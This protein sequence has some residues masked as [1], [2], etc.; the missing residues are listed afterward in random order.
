MERTEE[1]KLLREGTVV[2]LGGEEYR[3]RPLVSRYSGEWRKKSI[4]LITSLL[5]YEHLKDSKGNTE[6]LREFLN[7][8]FTTKTDEIIDSFF[9]YA[10]ELDREEIEGIATDGEIITAF[11][12]VFNVF[13]APLSVSPAPKVKE[14][15][16][17]SQSGLPSNSS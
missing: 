4:P 15:A 13:V 12:E 17:P 10:R 14:E 1:Q 8:F 11:M 6:E 3:I 2:I 9:E 16:S 7:E 5:A